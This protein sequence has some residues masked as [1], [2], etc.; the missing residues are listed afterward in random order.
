MRRDASGPR[1]LYTTLVVGFVVGLIAYVV[2]YL[3]RS[4]TP[5][6][7][8]GLLADLFY[9]FGLALWTGVVIA[10]FVQIY[11][12]AKRRQ[13]V[14]WLDAYEAIRRDTA[15]QKDDGGTLTA[16]SDLRPGSRLTTGGGLALPVVEAG[17]HR[18]AH[19]RH[20]RVGRAGYC[21]STAVSRA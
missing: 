8:L 7:P 4:T 20:G 11:P 21:R 19:R 16:A 5:T 1:I 6:E 15:R 18:P 13:Y 3:L 10:V 14:R 17:S 9:T 12:E 2:G